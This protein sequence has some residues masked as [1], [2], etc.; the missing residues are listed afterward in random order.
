M[1][2]QC[3][4]VKMIKNKNL[5]G[6]IFLVVVGIFA[7]NTVWA[8]S[9]GD[10]VLQSHYSDQ[11]CSAVAISE[12]CV[13]LGF[14]SYP[15]GNCIID[16]TQ[17][18]INDGKGCDTSC[19]VKSNCV[20]AIEPCELNKFVKLRTLQF[21]Y[22]FSRLDVREECALCSNRIYK[23]MSTLFDNS[24]KIE[25]HQ[26]RNRCGG[27]CDNPCRPLEKCEIVDRNG[28]DDEYDRNDFICKRSG[29]KC[30]RGW[31]FCNGFCCDDR[32]DQCVGILGLKH[33]SPK[34][35]ECEDDPNKRLCENTNH[36]KC[37]DKEDR[38][39]IAKLNVIFKEVTIDVC[40]KGGECEP[41]ETPCREDAAGNKTC[42]KPPNSDCK[43]PPKFDS[44]ICMPLDEN[45]CKKDPDGKTELCKSDK[46]QRC[47]KPDTCFIDEKGIPHCDY[48]T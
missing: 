29:E 47:C 43:I 18:G 33:C 35:K 45:D 3:M 26:D 17:T 48:E 24:I 21:G 30:P 11:S 8:F 15:V 19:N 37:C 32:Y 13:Y 23:T 9:A 38:C 12:E 22:G 20:G 39:G 28:D 2:V 7:I 42:C 34:K 5:V 6:I 4:D 40:I 1:R 25:D 27:N 44:P 16:C 10:I 36:P 31:T 41:G 14:C 46:G